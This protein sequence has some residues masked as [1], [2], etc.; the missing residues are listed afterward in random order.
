VILFLHRLE[1]LR[2]TAETLSPCPVR[3]SNR[4]SVEYNSTALPVGQPVQFWTV[5]WAIEI[6]STWSRKSLE[7]CELKRKGIPRICQMFRLFPWLII[8][9][10]VIH[11]NFKKTS[12]VYWM[13]C[14]SSN[15]SSGSLNL[16]CLWSPREFNAIKTWT[17]RDIQ[18]CLHIILYPYT[19][20]IYILSTHAAAKET[21]ANSMSWALLEKTPVAQQLYLFGIRRS[22][23]VFTR[24]FH[25]SLSYA[26]SI[27][28]TPLH[29]KA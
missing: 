28:S 10:S 25:W 8:G 14:Y 26:R 3:D 12:I 22:I 7:G 23:P 11:L 16:Y 13:L 27:Q 2:K 4:I 15:S 9:L 29:L 21:V 18:S 17:G 20:C 6:L 24:A 5:D 1:G 19:V